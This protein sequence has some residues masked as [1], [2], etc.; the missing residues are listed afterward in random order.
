MCQVDERTP[1]R[2]PSPGSFPFLDSSR[3]FL[4]YLSLVKSR[5]YL[6]LY[7]LP[8]G[9]A[10]LCKPVVRVVLVTAVFCIRSGVA[11]FIRRWPCVSGASTTQLTGNL[12][13][14]ILVAR[15]TLCW[16]QLLS[17]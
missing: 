10:F 14:L 8:A 11:L 17:F 15:S 12:R 5:L 1:R 7:M 2:L 9:S 3:T 4:C 13:A 16:S 6:R